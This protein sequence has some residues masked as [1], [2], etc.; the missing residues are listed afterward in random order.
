[1]R[2]PKRWGYR[3]QRRCGSTSA[4][5]WTRHLPPIAAGSPRRRALHRCRD[6][7]VQSRNPLTVAALIRVLVGIAVIGGYTP[8]PT[9]FD[10]VLVGYF[11]GNKLIFAAR[12]RNGFV[13][14]LRAAVFR[15]FKGLESR[16][17]PF[18]NLPERQGAL[19]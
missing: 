9:N 15:K 2:L 13:P 12:V 16:K 1:M 4:G 19:G 14:A 17:C 11:E 7:A 10:S 3:Q 18:A 8:S 6:F 5:R